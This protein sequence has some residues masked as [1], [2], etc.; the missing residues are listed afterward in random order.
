MHVSVVILQRRRYKEGVAGESSRESSTS[1]G[2]GAD[3]CF[4]FL[5]FWGLGCGEAVAANTAAT[6]RGA[7]LPVRGMKFL[8]L[9][10][11]TERLMTDGS[12]SLR[13]FEGTY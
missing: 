10:S 1:T 13:L 5:A 2:V 6:A 4:P 9:S 11:S 12:I 8:L 3:R 7:F